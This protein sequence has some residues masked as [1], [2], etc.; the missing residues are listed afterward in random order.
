MV[1]IYKNKIKLI[2]II[3]HAGQGIVKVAGYEFNII[4]P[5]FFKCFFGNA[6]GFGAA[7]QGVNFCFRRSF[8]QVKGGNAQAGA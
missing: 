5:A 7:F 1:A 6:G 3:N 2:K 8:L 4:Y